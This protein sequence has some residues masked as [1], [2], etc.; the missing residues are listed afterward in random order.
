MEQ[1]VDRSAIRDGTTDISVSS[2]LL[3]GSGLSQNMRAE[4]RAGVAP[5]AGAAER[6]GQL[7][8]G[9]A[10]GIKNRPKRTAISP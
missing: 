9:N 8:H 2:W 5:N 6:G 10:S 1:L 7:D 3:S 4:R